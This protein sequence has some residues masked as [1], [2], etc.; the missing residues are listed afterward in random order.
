MKQKN[1]SCLMLHVP[2][3][4]LTFIIFILVLGVLVVVHEF[5]HFW[6]ARRNGVRVDEF[7]FGFPPRIL[8]KKV[9]ETI[10]SLN[11]LP[12][13]GF[14]RIWGEDMEEGQND[15]RSF[16]TKTV[17]QRSRIIAAGV[18]MNVLLAI[19]ILSFIS[20]I[21]S[22]SAIDESNEKYA[23]NIGILI[24]GVA[25]DSPAQASGIKMGD[26]ITQLT[27]GNL[28]LTTEG[29]EEIQKFISE[30]KGQEITIKIQRKDE[31]VDIKT[32]PRLDPP[33]GEGALGIA[34]ARV[35]TV[36]YPIYLAPIKGA[37][38]T[39]NVA[40]N[41][42]VSVFLILKTWI[43]DGK[44]IGEVAGPVGIFNLTGEAA[45]LGFIYLLQFIAILS[46][47]LAIINILP[48][49]ALDGGR[50]LFL[51]LEKIKGSPVSV[52]WEKYAHIIGFILLIL[53]ILLITYKDVKRM[54]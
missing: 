5:G 15:P 18:V 25:K 36:K 48:I 46:V 6:I 43:V 30:N 13:G 4:M 53:L 34:M 52:K 19:V 14:V 12:L 47:N 39:Y 8:W 3:S 41:F 17:G 29:I 35:G 7:G 32:T 38:A 33:K 40:A 31:F 16:A 22:P 44:V 50:L 1:A 11:L 54:F 51:A 49:P 37:E 20:V 21:G 45:R 2:C 23:S 42:V 26:K 24:T 9:G 27:T 28:Q 10:Y